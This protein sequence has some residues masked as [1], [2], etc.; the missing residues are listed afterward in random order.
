MELEY[1][2]EVYTTLVVLAMIEECFTRDKIP[3]QLY[4]EQRKTYYNNY[5]SSQR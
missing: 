3:E 4:N 5:I 2:K 1:P